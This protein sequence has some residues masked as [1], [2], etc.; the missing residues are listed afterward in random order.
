MNEKICYCCGLE[1]TTREHAPS[2]GLFPP[3]YRKNLIT[4]PSCVVHNNLLSDF[5]AK[6]RVY[7]QA[8]ES[9]DV[10]KAAW[11]DKTVRS[12]NRMPAFVTEL[13]ET[14]VPIQDDNGNPVG[15]LMTAHGT[16]LQPYFEKTTRALYYL[17]ACRPSMGMDVRYYSRYY[18]NWEDLEKVD[19]FDLAFRDIE[20]E[21]G[22]GE[23]PEVFQWRYILTEQFFTVQMN[24]YQGVVVYGII[25]LTD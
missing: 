16:L 5:D 10:A 3:G 18:F 1:A 19:M 2:Q 8:P 17:K 4:V 15:G 12:F 22:S 24:F 21:V 11:K 9:N 25:K 23:N 13:D 14:T 20:S 7:L 6:V